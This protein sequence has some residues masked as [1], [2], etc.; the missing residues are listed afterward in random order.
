VVVV[1]RGHL[2]VLVWV[3]DLHRRVVRL[4]SEGRYEGRWLWVMRMRMRWMELP[5]VHRRRRNPLRCCRSILIRIIPVNQVSSIP[6]ANLISHEFSPPTFS[7]LYSH[8]RRGWEN[9]GSCSSSWASTRRAAELL[10]VAGVDDGGGCNKQN[11]QNKQNNKSKPRPAFVIQPSLILTSPSPPPH[12][13]SIIRF[14]AIPV[15]TPA[16]PLEHGSTETRD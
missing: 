2:R 16:L 12:L 13:T 8:R 11:K 1:D 9:E 10:G 4:L 7:Q 15:R 14:L 5:V 6:S 3:L